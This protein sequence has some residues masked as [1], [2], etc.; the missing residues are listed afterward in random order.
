MSKEQDFIKKQRL[1]GLVASALDGDA[2]SEEVH[3]LNVL[4]ME[5]E[6]NRKEFIERAAFE[7]ALED[8][9]KADLPSGTVSRAADETGLTQRHV[10]KKVARLWA[11]R[12]IQALLVTAAMVALYISLNRGLMMKQGGSRARVTPS[13]N[14]F[15]VVASQAGVEWET[16]VVSSGDVLPQGV[17][18]IRSG[19]IHLELFSGVQLVV[20]GEAKFV[21]ESPLVVTL[22]QGAVR[23][24]VPDVANGFRVVTA[25]G[26]IIDYGTEFNVRVNG[27]TTDV[28]VLDGEVGVVQSERPEIR[29]IRG[30]SL[31][32]RSAIAKPEVLETPVN[33]MSSSSVTRAA[34][35]SLAV[36][37]DTWETALQ[38]WLQDP[39]LVACYRGPSEQHSRVLEN[40]AVGG[41]AATQAIVVGA[42]ACANR[43]GRDGQA[44]D[45]TRFGSRSR[46]ALRDEMENISLVCWVKINGLSNLFNSLFLT[47]GHEEG[48]PH[49]QILKDGRIFF[50]VKHPHRKG[51]SWR[52]TV[53]YSPPIWRDSMSG[54]WNML[55]VTYNRG[56]GEV[57]HYLNGKQISLESIPAHATVPCINLRAASI[58]NW[59]EPM[60]RTD[61]EFTCRNLNGSVD[62]LLIFDG[63]L[64]AE[65][66]EEM[67][68]QSA[69]G[70]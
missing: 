62:E 63:V 10:T 40:L 7:C 46:V 47:D 53:F 26:K 3:A 48:E 18:H 61:E 6:R 70:E 56:S 50:S 20:E 12:G 55:A 36:R 24:Y 33:V 19:V 49:W 23:A 27:D 59:A 60:Y 67:Y 5:S 16:S 37:Q 69:V 45:Y 4:L 8:A 35:Q 42:T 68:S 52:Q 39:R 51:T 38:E 25:A 66:V 22:N 58:A 41:T 57:A 21:I 31:R 30:N 34:K 29:F 65:E 11:S 44:F 17:H 32:V 9:V 43:W 64:S 28:T 13:P 15:A 2:E 54:D 14:G 1:E